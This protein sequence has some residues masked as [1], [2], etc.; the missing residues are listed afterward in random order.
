MSAI[1]GVD[2]GGTKLLAVRIDSAG[3]VAQEYRTDKPD[4]GS[5]MAT[6]IANAVPELCGGDPIGALGVGVAGLVDHKTGT[7]VWGP[8]VD[9]VNVSLR[10]E[11]E[12][13]VG[14]RVTV[15]NDAN[16]TAFAEHRI[17]AGR[18]SSAMLMLTLGT[19]IG[20]A[21]VFGGEIYRGRG[22]AGEFGHARLARGDHQCECGQRGC[23]ETEAAGPALERLA[24]E[25]IESDPHGS[26]AGALETRPVAGPAISAAAVAG[27]P[28]AIALIAQVGEAFGHGL[29]SVITMFD[30]DRIVI[31]GGLGS[32]G[33]L[34]LDPIRRST[35]AARYAG[36]H[37]PL[38]TIVG[39]ELGEHAGAIGAG[40]LAVEERAADE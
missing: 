22:F 37:N 7:F 2:I 17:G 32:I 38:P 19:G 18:G 15:D 8:H 4:D 3:S 11:L 24:R 16:V 39:A 29:A 6:A 34:L 40:L 35:G 25:L 10:D 26:L 36:A 23:W 30:P 31:G 21:M 5:M 12:S 27:D 1:I 33:E 9:G 13:V 28:Q 20:G 14:S